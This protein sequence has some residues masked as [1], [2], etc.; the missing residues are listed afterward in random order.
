MKKLIIILSIL[1]FPL[2]VQARNLADLNFDLSADMQKD[3]QMA[4]SLGCFDPNKQEIFISSIVKPEAII[5]VL[6]HEIGHFLLQDTT[7]EQY[8]EVFGQGSL[9]ELQEKAANYFYE[10]IWLPDFVPDN[11]KFFFGKLLSS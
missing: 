6:T 8:Q 11:I 9:V 1:L 7:L 10:F 4:T 2:F 3:C 5:F